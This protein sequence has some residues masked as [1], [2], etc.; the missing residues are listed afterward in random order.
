MEGSGMPVER[1]PS[2]KEKL[3][4][5]E[6][7]PIEEEFIMVKALGILQPQSPIRRP[8]HKQKMQPPATHGTMPKAFHCIPGDLPACCWVATRKRLMQT[9]LVTAASVTTTVKPRTA[10]DLTSQQ[11]TCQATLGDHNR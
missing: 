7:P 4:A 9:K 5:E 6:E 3:S 10:S 1:R 11:P 8:P 2:T